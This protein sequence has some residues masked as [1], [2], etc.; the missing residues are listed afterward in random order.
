VEKDTCGGEHRSS[1]Q[2]NARGP[3]VYA[4]KAPVNCKITNRVVGSV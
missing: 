4:G 2:L 1:V 3:H